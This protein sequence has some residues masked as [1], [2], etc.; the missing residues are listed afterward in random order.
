MTLLYKSE[1]SIN[2]TIL[3]SLVLLLF[4]H[5]IK[6]EFIFYYPLLGAAYIL[7]IFQFLKNQPVKIN[8][9]PVL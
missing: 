1:N 3:F 2:Q 9:T 7:G 4:L 6:E 8:Q 5:F